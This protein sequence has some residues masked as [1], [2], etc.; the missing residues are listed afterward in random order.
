MQHFTLRDHVVEATRRVGPQGA[1]ASNAVRAD[2]LALLEAHAVR[3]IGDGEPALVFVHGF[4]VDQ[5]I[6]RAVAPRFAPRRRVVLFDQMG[7]GRSE[8]GGADAGRYRS[9]DGYADDLAAILDALGLRD[10]V[11]IGHS[12]AGIV[13]LMA[14]A[15]TDRIGRL[16]M[17]GSSARYLND[18]GYRGGFEREEIDQL[19]DFLELDFQG[20]VRATATSAAGNPDRPELAEEV[21]HSFSRAHPEVIRHFARA[22]FLLDARGML[23]ACAT[24]TLVLQASADSIVTPEAAA[25]LASHIPG[26]V[27]KTLAASGHYP[28]LSGPDEVVAAIEQALGE[29]ALGEQALGEQALG[30]Q[31]LG[32]RAG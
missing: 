29:Q 2:R 15:R 16:V 27:L 23:A 32:E 4:G 17:I 6:W 24:P 13:A 18:A 26:A 1:P 19:L 3:V 10:C 7:C 21:A 20:W 12:I 9:L 11:V 8:L 14:A 31:A 30:E 28:Q 22:T 5:T 25:Y